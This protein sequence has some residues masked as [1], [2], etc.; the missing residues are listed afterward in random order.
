M[1]VALAAPAIEVV[2]ALAILLVAWAAGVLLVKP[3]AALLSNLPFIGN[4]I[5]DRLV[6]GI[7]AVT[8]WALDLA[9]SGIHAMVQ[10]V[11]VP[12][13]AVAAVVGAI[14]G[15]LEA[16]AAAIVGLVGDLA[17]L[18]MQLGPRIATLMADVGI[19]AG[20]IAG[21]VASIPGIAADVA[22]SVVGSAETVLRG[23]IASVAAG[24][25][26]AIAAEHELILAVRGD[27][28]AFIVG[29]VGVLSAAIGATADQLRAE[30]AR[31]LAP[32]SAQVG[33]LAGVVAGLT[34]LA[35]ATTIPFILTEITQL[36]K[37]ADPLC[38]T[39]SPS[40]PAL[41]AVMSLAS[42]GLVGGLV[43]E[44]MANPQ[45]AARGAA[46]VIG[47]IESAAGELFA[48]FTGQAA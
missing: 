20:R 32:V 1:P 40:L 41:D 8:T 17:Q 33:Q 44:A 42:I 12:I 3:L 22:R 10:L 28:L 46:A 27:V 14:V 39:L 19:L 36:R 15:G 29:Q 31:D 13:T 45:A 6:K 38:S 2:A 7:D 21:V 9:K 11:S 23:I 48:L 4:T 34:P 30:W 43:G 18:A 47:D 5:A 37:C 35:L 24:L 25:S 16:A 26:A